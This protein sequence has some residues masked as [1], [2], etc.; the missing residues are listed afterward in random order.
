MSHAL[1]LTSW[2]TSLGQ[3]SGTALFIKSLQK[4]VQASGRSVELVNPALD[5]RDYT[6]FTLDR[7]WFNIQ[8]AQQADRVLTEA[9]WILGLDYDGF[10]LPRRSGQPFIASLRAVFADLIDTEPDPFRTMLRAQAYFEGQIVRRADWI[11]TPSEYARSKI[12]EYYGVNESKVHAI[13]NG[14]DLVEW[15]AHW[16]AISE[17]DRARRPTLLAVSK[18]YP[19]KKIDTLIRAVPLLRQHLPD[20][21]VR[22]VGGGFEWDALQRL[23]IELGV[24][25]HVT[26]LGDINDRRRVVAEFKRCHVFTHPS[27]QDAFANVCLE[28]MAAAKPLV[29]SD[30]ASMPGLVRAGDSGLIVP[31]NDPAALAQAVSELFDDETRRDQLG[32][33]GRRFAETMTWENTSAQFLRL[34][35]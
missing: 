9:A 5:T 17:P 27:I 13:P 15:D 35:P 3:G 4:A 8:F 29:V 10:A 24:A 11:T 21:D 18:L 28:S 31:P 33:N 1:F 32:C 12:V 19:R 30:A 7:F 2:P 22:I 23:T 34:I 26:W 6:Q 25:D 20:I 14:I 16:A